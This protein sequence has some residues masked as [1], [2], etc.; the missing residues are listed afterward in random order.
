M[1]EKYIKILLVGTTNVGKNSLFQ[2]LTIDNNKNSGI[3]DMHIIDLKLKIDVKDK[4]NKNI[5]KLC[6]IKICYF[7]CLNR[8]NY[9]SKSYYENMDGIL[10]IYDVT[11]IETYEKVENWIMDIYKNSGNEYVIGI[12]G[13]KTDLIGVDG[14]E[15][16]IDEENIR[17]RYD[18]YGD[19]KFW[20]RECSIK[21]YTS[22][23]LKIL[24]KEFIKKIYK[25][26]ENK[27]ENYTDKKHMK[28]KKLKKTK[29]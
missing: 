25:N 7:N 21:K 2:K 10:F 4:Y 24:L 23:E 17:E 19:N 3:F 28:I 22:D 5:T 26:I 1:S 9:L 12:L 13:N 18:Q 20:Y 14:K 8:M 27:A 15:R 11:N 6:K 29:K 16:E